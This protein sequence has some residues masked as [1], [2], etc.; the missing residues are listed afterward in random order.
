MC[1]AALHARCLAKARHAELL[2][3]RTRAGCHSMEQ[4][5]QVLGSPVQA[6]NLFRGCAS[7]TAQASVA[8]AQ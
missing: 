3:P 2:S 6:G 1:S 5:A 4:C 7:E 8:A